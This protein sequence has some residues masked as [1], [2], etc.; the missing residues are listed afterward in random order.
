MADETTDDLLRKI[1]TELQGIKYQTERTAKSLGWLL[2]LSIAGI[3]LYALW[4]FGAVEVAS[5]G[6]SFG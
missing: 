1:G 3:A 2:F 5:S 4:L 6:T